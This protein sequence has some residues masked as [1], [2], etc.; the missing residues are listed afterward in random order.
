[1]FKKKRIGFIIE[2]ISSY[3]E[4][5]ASTRLR[6]YDVI[7]F[8]NK[9]G[10]VAELYNNNHLYDIIIF[11]KCFKKHHKELAEQLKNEGTIVILDININIIEVDNKCDIFNDAM[12]IERKKQCVD[13]KE[14]VKIV[15]H[16]LVSS[17]ALLNVYSNWHKSVFCI[18]EN[19][20]NCFFKCKKK[21]INNKVRLLYQGYAIKAKE[22][23]LIQDV[24][25]RLHSEFN[26]KI[27][28]ISDFD[29]MLDIIPYDFLQYDQFKLPE[30]I[31]NADIKIAP[32]KLDNLYNQGHSFNK[33]AYPMAVGLP[34][35]ASPVPSYLN[36]EVC[37][38]CSSDE[39]YLTLKSLILNYELRNYIGRRGRDFI[40]KNFSMKKIGKE[41]IDFI[42]FVY[43]NK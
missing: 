22:L 19:V 20:A 12:E 30:Q 35:V 43:R 41:Y 37:I 5:M 23:L 28:F 39:W 15:D 14:M 9:N 32:R 21:H 18:E 29:P 16:V 34:A 3:S 26:I 38:C 11:Q 42:N 17:S 6:C 27:L 25:V 2:T 1:M 13:V 33:V 36:R 7:K 10:I 40:K 31:L 24:L 8:L 4:A